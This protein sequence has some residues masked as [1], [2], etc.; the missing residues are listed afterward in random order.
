M[1]NGG[2]VDSNAFDGFRK[3]VAEEFH[4][5]YCFNLRGDQR[6]AGE[7]SKQEGGKIFGSGSR[8]GVAIVLL[9]KKPGESP[10]AT[11][12][13]HDIGDYLNRDQ[14]LE[15][16]AN[17]RLATTEWRVIS[18]NRHHDW[19][20]QRSDTFPTLRPLASEDGTQSINELAP[21]FNRQ[22]LGLVTSRDDWC[23][24]SSEQQLRSNIQRSVDFY[25]DQVTAFRKTK[26]TGSLKERD[27][28]ARAFVRKDPQQFHW[29]RENYRDLANGSLYTV[30]EAGFTFSSYRPFFKQ[31]LYFNRELNNSI[32]QFPE[33]YPSP[34]AENLGIFL[35]GPGSSSPFLA[36][37]TN[38]IPEYHIPGA[39]NSGMYLSR[40]RY[41]PGRS[42]GAGPPTRAL[43]PDQDCSGL[44]PVSNINSAALAEFRAHYP[45]QAITEDDLFYYTYGVL[46]SPQWRETYANDLAKEHAR[47][48]MAA[49][50]DDFRAFVAVGRQL[51]DLHVNYETV[52]P[53]P[54]EEIHREGWIPACAGMTGEGGG[55]TAAAGA[56]R[57]E[58]MTYAGRRPHPDTSRIIYN[59]G[60]TLAGIPAAA[61]EYQLG[62]R[63]ALDWLIDRY[64]VRT[65]K[66]SGIVNDPNDWCAEQGQ[67]RYIVDLVKRVTTVSVRTVE[68]VRSLPAV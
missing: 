11:V 29:S 67:P 60:I 58:K 32:R 54:L 65:H 37:M 27:T 42:A 1:T 2:F 47:I 63:S 56:Y 50:G 3:A 13:Y 51:A 21:L 68:I 14:K 59:A 4:A 10:G 5:I 46:H 16:L 17:S 36:L 7:K 31:Y 49:S 24:A 39:G 28:K 53:Y 55:M 48:P 57:V 43:I 18:P 25:N 9:V 30:D 66:A 40:W 38:N 15:T 6:T 8:A 23:Y 45:D 26:P 34:D 61:H 52:E 44:K 62:S 19:I 12:Y 41:V 22:T 20:D 33:I 64:Q 35:T